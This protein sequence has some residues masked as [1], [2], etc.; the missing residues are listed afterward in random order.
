MKKKMD[1]TR[2][3]FLGKAGMAV[4]S[5]SIAGLVARD[6]S[7]SYGRHDKKRFHNRTDDKQ[8]NISDDTVDDVIDEESVDAN[9]DEWASGGTDLITLDYPD[10]TLFSSAGTCSL[11]LTERTTEGP[12]Y[13]G[14]SEREDI[15]D[16]QIGLPMMLCM[17]VVDQDCNPLEGYLVEVW[18]CNREGIYSGDETQSDDTS[19]FAGSFCTADDQEA[20]SSTWFRGE[21]TTDSSGRVNFKTCFPGWYSGRTIHIHFRIRLEYGGADYVVSQ[22][23]FDDSFCD[24]IC[25]TH[26][27]YSHRGA[28]N[29]P[30]S[31]GNDTVF[32]DTDYEKFMMNTSKND[33]GTLLGYKRVVIDV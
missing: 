1:V 9:T 4:L 15:S 26:S 14:V 31:G 11:V 17:Q 23:C 33:D 22:F 20:E 5:G 19:T 8:D 30:L 24:D 28:Q 2:R 16:G 25:T 12:C 29:T 3:V 21:L 7:A 18:H 6:V 13:L 27:L 32:P 10:D